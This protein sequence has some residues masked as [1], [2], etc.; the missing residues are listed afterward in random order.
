MKLAIISDSHDHYGNLSRAIELANE[1]GCE[2]MLFAGDLIAPGNGTAVLSTFK[3][4]VHFI[5]GNNDGEEFGMTKQ[6]AKHEHLSIEGKTFEAEIDGVKIFMNHYPRIAEIAAHS[7][8]FD[9]VIY[10][11]DHKY[12]EEKVGDCVLLNPGAIHPYKIPCA[13]F[14][15]FDTIDRS[16]NRIEL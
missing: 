9:L 12:F 4:D 5:Y 7:G 3:G 2:R 16:V 10:G 15:I 1:A 13:S 11:H 14:V 8:L 6:F